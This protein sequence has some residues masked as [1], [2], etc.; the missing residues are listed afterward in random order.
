MALSKGQVLQGRYRIERLLSEGGM[1]AVYE[2]FD[3]HLEMTVALKE[4]FF[5][6]KES[7]AQFKREALMLAK[8]HHRGLP[9]VTNHFEENQRQ[10]LVMDFVEGVDLWEMLKQ[11]RGPLT[12]QVAIDYVVQLCD[13]LTYLHQQSPPIIHRDIKP[14]N[15]KITPDNRA[16]LVD[17]GI[18]KQESNA[19]TV[20][21]AKGV[22]PGFSPPEQYVGGTKP[23]SDIYSL[24]ATLYT[25]VT[26]EMPEDSISLLTT[27][28]TFTP[29]H[30][31]NP[32][33]S[34]EITDVIQWATKLKPEERPQSAEELKRRLLT[35]SARSRPEA[36]RVLRNDEVT[37]TVSAAS[38]PTVTLKRGAN[39]PLKTINPSLTQLLVRLGWNAGQQV[40]AEL[41][42]DAMAF[43]LT[44]QGTVRNDQDL[45]FYNNL[46]SACGAVLHG[47]AVP[48][49]MIGEETIEI[50]L[51][52]VSAEIERVIFTM[53]IYDAE[54][55]SQHFGMLKEAYVCLVNQVTGH[56]MVRYDLS[57]AHNHETA[58][59]FGQLYR[60]QDGWRFR[61]VGQGFK[62]GI[63]ALAR[64]YGV[65]IG[66]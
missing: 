38:P 11:V 64:H 52:A 55:R 33:L 3:R 6:V 49:M 1:G 22:T 60:H 42:L 16:I 28:Q 58:M 7:K 43:M 20:L 35:I 27:A 2:A 63:E 29:A 59:I 25:L 37:L 10:Y 44:A 17:F 21:G 48:A 57:E 23:A 66:A 4:N 18:A 8:L 12:Q 53:S 45:I 9:R 50:D 34:P 41:D 19:Q 31:I 24:G 46:K 13:T 65:S 51:T 32:N 14:Q 39:V 40:G 36:T 61:A 26:A 15:I 30:Q 5:G 56:E 62:D 47:G 54:G